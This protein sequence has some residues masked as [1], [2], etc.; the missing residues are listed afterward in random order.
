MVEGNDLQPSDWSET[1]LTEVHWYALGRL[2]VY[3]PH[4]AEFISIW[5][6]HFRKK[7]SLSS[8]FPLDN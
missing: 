4:K 1:V 5:G 2:S 7:K 8:L 6:S 3:I